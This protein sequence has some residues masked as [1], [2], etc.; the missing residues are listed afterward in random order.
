MKIKPFFTERFFAAH[1]FTAPYLLSASDCESLTVDEVLQLAR[2]SWETLGRL[3]LGYTESQGAPM[4]RE[5]IATMYTSATADQVIGL[6]APEEGIFLTMHALLQRGDEVIVLSP[7]YDSLANVAEYL[8]CRVFRW[9]L[10]EIGASSAD[11]AP[12][13]GSGGW[14]LDLVTLEKLI[15]PRTALVIVNFPHNPTGYLPSHGEWRALVQI[16]ERAGAWLFADEMYRGLEYDPSARLASACDLYQRAI[17][18]GGL[19]KTYGLP[20][21]R[22]GWLVLQDTDLRERLLGW[23]D[24]TTICA[25]APGE[26][27]AEI[28]L[29]VAEQL[30]ERSRQIIQGNLALAEPFFARWQSILRWNRPQAGSVALVGLRGRSAQEF[31]SH[32]VAERGVLL[33]PSTGLGFGDGHVRFGFGRLSFPDALA[34][35]DDYLAFS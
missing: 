18:L 26:V 35:L 2:V 17:T 21:L 11:D 22:T 14:Q 31:A 1:E 6:S 4:L 7:C 33:L 12:T 24:Y 15:T 34:Q 10:L 30:A 13:E 8:G 20:G 25:S 9:P 27:L 23:K 29:R 32:L 5:R 28:A 3:T 19:S 16:V